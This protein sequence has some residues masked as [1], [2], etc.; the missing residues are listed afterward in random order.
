M[1]EL[2]ELNINE[3]AERLEKTT[4]YNKLFCILMILREKGYD[5]S[6]WVE[7][8]IAP[9]KDKRLIAEFR[10]VMLMSEKS[11]QFR[12]SLNEM[13]EDK[14]IY[15]VKRN[16]NF[17][18]YLY[19]PTARV[20]L[21]VFQRDKGFNKYFHQSID[22]IISNL[23]EKELFKVLSQEPELIKYLNNPTEQYLIEAVKRNPR[24]IRYLDC[25][26]KLSKLCAKIPRNKKE[27]T[28]ILWKFRSDQ[29]TKLH[30]H[31]LE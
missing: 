11:A 3:L 26:E 1:N 28:R 31:P 24:V 14:I 4:E 20:L 22:E 23:P 18:F 30:N 2:Y 27:F 19:K 25:P 8:I 29:T 17:V 16:P 9:L 13:S 5:I 7:K 12:L 15:H 21:A 10:L 6:S